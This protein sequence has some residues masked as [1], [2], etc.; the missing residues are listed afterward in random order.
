[1]NKTNHRNNS[2]K[3]KCKSQQHTFNTEIE[4]HWKNKENHNLQANNFITALAF[5]NNTNFTTKEGHVLLHQ[6][7]SNYEESASVITKTKLETMPQKNDQQEI[8]LTPY[9][10]HK[11]KWK[12]IKLSSHKLLPS[13]QIMFKSNNVGSPK[14]PS[15]TTNREV[16]IGASKQEEQALFQNNPT[17]LQ[18][19]WKQL[20]V[21]EEFCQWQRE[22]LIMPHQ[23]SYQKNL[24]QESEDV[25]QQCKFHAKKLRHSDNNINI[26]SYIL[27][28][29]SLNCEKHTPANDW[30]I[31]KES[32][33]GFN[34]EHCRH[35]WAETNKIKNLRDEDTDK[36]NINYKQWVHELL[37][38]STRTVIG[39]NKT[40]N[41]ESTSAQHYRNQN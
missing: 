21:T 14:N 27:S 13:K 1:M 15:L 26:I 5:Y 36:L 33:K 8:R 34:F 25:K 41:E 16:L 18:K 7:N 29:I 23:N 20:Q 10:E 17:Q 22:S 6:Q 32:M 12:F 24:K 39:S 28:T 4:E 2:P 9:G 35:E 40:F 37:R 38:K 19:Q 31:K 11:N 30:K 3:P